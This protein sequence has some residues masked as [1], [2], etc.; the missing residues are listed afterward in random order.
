MTSG[1]WPQDGEISIQLNLER[2]HSFVYTVV[3]TGIENTCS[4][5]RHLPLR[6]ILDL[7]L[8]AITIL[9]LYHVGER[10][11]PWTHVLLTGTNRLAMRA[12]TQISASLQF[13]PF[14]LDFLKRRFFVHITSHSDTLRSVHKYQHYVTDGCFLQHVQVTWSGVKAKF[15]G[16]KVL[17]LFSVGL[18]P[19]VGHGLLIFFFFEVSWSHTTTH[20]SR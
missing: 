18:R 4:G 15:L 14:E 8:F 12:M 11:R 5:C 17:L 2:A 9:S 20:H 7:C 19:N 3:G 13:L 1:N 16:T 10:Q 6:H